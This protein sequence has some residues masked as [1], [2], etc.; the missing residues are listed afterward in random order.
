MFEVVKGNLVHKL[1]Y[2]DWDH[3]D[4]GI[5]NIVYPFVSIGTDAEYP[6]RQ[7]K[8]KVVIGSNNT[9]REYVTIN[10]PVEDVTLVGNNNYIMRN[11]HLG[12]DC[13]IENDCTLACNSIIGG[14]AR[15]MNGAF[16]GLG[17]AVHQFGIIGSYSLLGINAVVTKKLEV[18]PGHIY[19][20]I[21]AKMIKKNLVGLSRKNID[22]SQLSLEI[23]RFNKLKNDYSI[24]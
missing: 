19:A 21:P 16:T 20:G 15:I 22:D 1:A 23:D 14:H 10:R 12:H 9:I 17:S 24:K 11:S 5:D 4:I 13:I 7:S 6:G 8:G 2:V 3:V 18:L